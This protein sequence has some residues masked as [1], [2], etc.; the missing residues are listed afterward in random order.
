MRP[1][2]ISRRAV[3]AAGA[4]LCAAAPL[5]ALA[6][7]M[8]PD[9]KLHTG[10]T[11]S[12]RVGEGKA[13]I[14]WNVWEFN[15]DHYGGEGR[16]VWALTRNNPVP[17]GG[18]AGENWYKKQVAG[19]LKGLG[20]EQPTEVTASTSMAGS[21][22]ADKGPPFDADFNV[23]YRKR[24]Q[25][26]GNIYALKVMQ[27]KGRLLVFDLAPGEQRAMPEPAAEFARLWSGRLRDMSPNEGP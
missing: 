22:V 10:E 2:L 5:P 7:D 16:I 25:F 21:E 4:V 8:L 17:R 26:S 12:V 14:Y 13:G 3:L 18:K 9:P 20:G 24:E 27:G 1:M 15:K 11:R 23:F 19:V 6:F